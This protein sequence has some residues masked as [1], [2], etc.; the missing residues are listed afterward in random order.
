MNFTFTDEQVAIGELAERILGDLLPPERLRDIEADGRWFAENAWAALATADLL[1]L[2]LPDEVG[3]GGYGII[4]ACIVAE[5]VGRAAAPLPVVPTLASAM[6][7]AAHGSADLRRAILPSVVDGTTILTAAL[8]EPGEYTSPV[9][10]TTRASREGEG[11]RLRGAKSLVP[12]AHL[13]SRMLVPARTGDGEGEGDTG[14]FLVDPSARGVTLTREHAVSLE[15]QWSVGLDDVVVE[16]VV[17]DPRAG[18]HIVGE[19]VELTTAMLCWT[20][21]GV[22]ES[23]LRLTAA[24]VSER[25]QFGAKLGT[26]Q[27]VSNRCADAYIDTEAVRLTSW[28]AAWRLAAGLPSD[29]ALAVAKFWA[30]DGS[31]RVV[32]AAQHLHGGIGVDTDYPLHR[33]FRWAKVLE[34]TLGGATTSLLRLGELLAH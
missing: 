5:Q 25:E 3:G 28:Q 16:E 21:L 10:P 18:A 31:Q 29:E 24:H 33:Y 32:H 6:V 30:A 20:T 12:A 23:A 13:A 15:P 14:L 17:G 34:L 19:L 22:C 9:P 8:A 1:G 7:I 26:F 2:C 4:E 27:A 11:W